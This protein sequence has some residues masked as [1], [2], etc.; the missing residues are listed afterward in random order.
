[1]SRCQAAS[2]PLVSLPVRLGP[3]SS[4]Y[5]EDCPG[6]SFPRAA[7]EPGSIPLP[8]GTPSLPKTCPPAHW[9]RHFTHGHRSARRSDPSHAGSLPPI[10]SL[11]SAVG[12]H[13]D[14]ASN[15]TGWNSEAAA[16]PHLIATQIHPCTEPSNQPASPHGT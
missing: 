8:G 13:A 11:Q 2:T 7:Y 4:P 6:G 14:R 12:K 1:M 10:R 16:P 15:L 3:D 5:F 9:R